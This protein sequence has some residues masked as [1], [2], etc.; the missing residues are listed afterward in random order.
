MVKAAYRSG[1]PRSVW[2]RVTQPVRADPLDPG[3][4]AG[5]LH[6]RAHAHRRE[7]PVRRASAQEHGAYPGTRRPPVAQ[8]GDQ[9]L[10]DV[11]RQR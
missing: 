5:A 9:R 10:A 11:V 2:D 1:T 6:D 4:V 7:R 8:V 3:A